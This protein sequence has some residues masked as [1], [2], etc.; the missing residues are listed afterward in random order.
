MDVAGKV[1]VVTGAGSGIGRE[2]TIELVRRGA[3][4][5]AVDRDA[6]SLLV[7]RAQVGEDSADVAT[8]PLDIND[9]DGVRALPAQVIARFG[10][11]DGL[12]NNAG[13]I[14]PFVK[15]QDLDDATID[16]VMAVNWTGTLAMV[17]AF[18]PHLLARPVAH[19]ANISSMGGFLPVPGQ[20]IYGASKA[21]VKLM[22]EGLHAELADTNVGVTVV[23]PGAIA[24]NIVENSGVAPPAG[25]DAEAGAHRAT[26]ADVAA[27]TILDAIARDAYR[28]NVGSDASFLDMF[29]RL[30]PKWAAGF[31][32]RQ[33]A[34]L[35]G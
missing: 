3:R 34:D 28:V 2:L 11:V 32:A 24:T 19:I 31:I 10:A 23:F 33:M 7:T 6:A 20:T 12:I 1:I 15:L 17:R 9:L 26:A 29:Y 27:R 16:R 5:A 14:Q 22:T 30:A 13:I 4:V 25:V 18:L 21:A 35:L 8:F